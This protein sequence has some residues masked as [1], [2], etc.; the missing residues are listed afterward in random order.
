VEETVMCTPTRVLA[1]LAVSILAAGCDDSPTEPGD[2]PVSFETVALASFSGFSA[3][4]QQVVRT[5]GDWA[6]AWETLY[7]GQ[8]PVPPLPAIDFARQVV[9]LAAMGPKS[10]GCFRVEVTGV[11]RKARVSL[12]IEV[13]DFEPGPSCGCP[14]VVTQPA[15]VV[16][17]DRFDGPEQ[18][19]LRRRQVS[20]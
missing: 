4:R 15:H 14:T 3:P 10:N 1:L 18:F 11:T 17:L 16:K 5:D 6:G 19:V 20:C 12:E 8:S 13:T 2:V 9:V 7:A